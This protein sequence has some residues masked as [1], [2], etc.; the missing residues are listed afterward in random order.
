M[1][2]FVVFLGLITLYLLVFPEVVSAQI[3][4]NEVLNNPKGEES[5][6]EWVELF[7][8]DSSPEPLNGCVLFLDDSATSQKVIFDNEDFVEKYKVISWDKSWLNNNGDQIRLEC[9]DQVESVSYGDSEGSSL[10][11]PKDG[12]TFGRNPD[13]IGD[14][15][16]LASATLG[17]PNSAPPT[18]TPAPTDTLI[19]TPKPTKTP[20][21]STTVR[22]TNTPTLVRVVTKTTFEDG[23]EGKEVLG[24]NEGE[25]KLLETREGKVEKEEVKVAGVSEKPSQEN[26]NK[27]VPIAALLTLILGLIVLGVSVYPVIKSLILRYN[28]RN[29]EKKQNGE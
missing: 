6:A 13:G 27:K 26:D 22:F 10:E 7:N 11:A 2:S 14:F 23:G 20:A 12:I 28:F 8:R 25:Q 18:F 19:S 15:V 21:P 3:V 16:I 1:A 5:G 4:I 29:G 17:E 24:I 9:E